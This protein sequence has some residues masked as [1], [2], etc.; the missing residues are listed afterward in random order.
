IREAVD[1]LS[2]GGVVVYPTDTLYGLGANALESKAVEK[3]F[4]IKGR[5][6]SK[7]LPI[8]VKNL[9]WADELAY[10]SPRNQT[11]LKKAWPGKFTAILPKKNTVLELISAGINSVGIRIPDFVFTDKLLGKFGYPLT[12]TSANVSGQEPTNDI[13]KIIGTFSARAIQPDLVIDAGILP[14]SEPSVIVDLTG[15]KLKILRISPTSPDKLLK[16]LD[17]IVDF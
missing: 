10:I 6:F 1:V 13:N 12:A 8:I 4:T 14:P 7:P 5:D 2:S 3:I 17:P 9:V 11:I 16:L 15:D